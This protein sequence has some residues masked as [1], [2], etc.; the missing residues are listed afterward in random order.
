[1]MI[2][3]EQRDD[4]AGASAQPLQSQEIITCLFQGQDQ[5]IVPSLR[6]SPPL[7]DPED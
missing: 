1:M 6:P 2:S 5:A 4:Q 3:E 7:G